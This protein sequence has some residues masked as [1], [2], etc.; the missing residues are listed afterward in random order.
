MHDGSVLT[1]LEHM[2]QFDLRT[3]APLGDAL[4]GLRGYPLREEA[5]LLYVAL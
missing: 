1:C 2:W 5:G 4:E 3:G